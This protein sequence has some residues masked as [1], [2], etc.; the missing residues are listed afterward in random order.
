MSTTHHWVF[1]SHAS[2]T[3][4]KAIGLAM[5]LEMLGID[6][7]IAGI[8]LRGGDEW[9]S[10]IVR[11]ID[12]S[13]ALVVILSPGANASAWVEREVAL[14]VEREVRVIPVRFD[15]TEP[16]GGLALALAGLERI[17]LSGRSYQ[18]DADRIAEAFRG[19][20]VYPPGLLRHK[21]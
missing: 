3:N 9:L 20:P 14:A 1:I 17:D 18:A 6:A 15:W 5:G 2:D 11:V 8:D 16:E 4:R 21:G 19:R 10:E 12:D 13:P 7:W